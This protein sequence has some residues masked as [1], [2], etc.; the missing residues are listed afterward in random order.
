MDIIRII[1]FLYPN[2]SP[3]T[4]K[5]SSSTLKQPDARLRGKGWTLAG[6]LDASNQRIQ[7]AKGDGEPEHAILRMP[8]IKQLSREGAFTGMLLSQATDYMFDRSMRRVAKPRATRAKEDLN[9]PP[10]LGAA[11]V[12]NILSAISALEQKIPGGGA[13]KGAGASHSPPEQIAPAPGGITL[14][15]ASHELLRKMYNS[16]AGLDDA[17]KMVLRQQDALAQRQAPNANQ[18]SSAVDNTIDLARIA[19]RLGRIEEVQEEILSLLKPA[20]RI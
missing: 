7:A 17:R 15:E 20:Q 9:T 8:T 5:K 14:S 16:L 18:T 13:G 10:S 11:G 2:M 4:P 12:S 1:S 19:K 3:A 6:L